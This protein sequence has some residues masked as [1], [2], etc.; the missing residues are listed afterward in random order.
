MQET[1][2]RNGTVI[3]AIIALSALGLLFWKVQ[4]PA[5]LEQGAPAFLV[6][7]DGEVTADFSDSLTGNAILTNTPPS[8]VQRHG[9]YKRCFCTRTTC[10]CTP[11][12]CFQAR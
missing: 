12:G 10:K 5:A 3:V 1:L 4:D 9:C 11:G 7:D 2:R 8:A 6:W